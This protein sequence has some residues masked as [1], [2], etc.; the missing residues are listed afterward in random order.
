[1]STQ[2]WILLKNGHCIPEREMLLSSAWG[3]LPVS[4][5][6]DHEEINFCSYLDVKVNKWEI[7]KKWSKVQFP[8]PN[9]SIEFF[10]KKELAAFLDGKHLPFVVNREHDTLVI[11]QVDVGGWDIDQKLT[12]ALASVIAGTEPIYVQDAQ[13]F[14]A[15]YDFNEK[16]KPSI[17]EL[18]ALL[19]SLAG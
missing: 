19:S 5:S 6:Q 18:K 4:Y 8:E 13:G 17:S 7:D 15:K 16:K 2:Y 10:R 14:S 11:L 9:I 1:M 12:V 3:D